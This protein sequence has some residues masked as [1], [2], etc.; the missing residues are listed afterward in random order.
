MK[1]TVRTEEQHYKYI[2]FA[3]LT[4][5]ERTNVTRL[6]RSTVVSTVAKRT[7]TFLYNLQPCDIFHDRYIGKMLNDTV[8]TF[9]EG[10]ENV[11]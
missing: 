2:T 10:N 4:F 11:L 5:N 7:R 9:T 6:L 1:N 3:R 8:Q